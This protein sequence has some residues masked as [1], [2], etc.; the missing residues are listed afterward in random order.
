VID[1]QD[2]RLFDVWR[3]NPGV[4]DHA[5]ASS[6]LDPSLRAFAATLRE[7]FQIVDLRRVDPGMGFSWG[8]YG[9]RTEVR[10][11][12]YERIFAYARPPRTGLLAK[13]FGR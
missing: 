9:P 6:S 3:R 7:E 5:T 12:G 13:L 4:I 1:V 8:R 2:D 10:R 11:Y